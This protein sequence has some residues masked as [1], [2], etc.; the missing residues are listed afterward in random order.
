MLEASGGL[1]LF[2]LG[3]IIL[4][5]GLRGLAGNAI[6]AAL[7]RYTQSP[8]SGA[9][10]GAITTALLQSSSATTVAAV[11]F[12]GAGLMSFPNALGIIFGANIGTTMT[13]WI[14]AVVGFKLNLGLLAYP[15]IMLGVILRLLGRGRLAATGLAIAGFGLIFAGIELLQTAMGGLQQFISPDTLPG[16]SFSGRLVLV[17]LGMVFTII[18]Q[19][20][21][22]GVATALTALHTGAIQFE[23]AAAL[24]IGMDVGTTVTAA[25]ATIGSSVNGKRTGF[26]HVIY[27]IMT[28]AGAFLL[29]TPY[30]WIWQQLA[31]G[32]L[33]HHAEIALVGFHSGFNALGVLAVLPFTYPFARL[34]QQLIQSP[35]KTFSRLFDP[36]LLAQPSEAL[37]EVHK[38]AHEHSLTLLTQLDYLLND[39]PTHRRRIDMI[40]LQLA[41]DETHHFIDRIHLEKL[42][43]PDNERM[44]NLLHLLDHLQ[45][46]HERCDEDTQRAATARES[47]YLRDNILAFKEILETVKTHLENERWIEASN[48]ME[49]T[50]AETK[51]ALEESRKRI[52]NEMAIDTIDVPPGTAELEAIR[53]LKRVNHHL[54]RITL[55]FRQE[56]LASGKEKKAT[57]LQQ[58]VPQNDIS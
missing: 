54:R 1:G 46:L 49:E 18:T 13:G 30:L 8:T 28:G 10:T 56:V 34:M 42:G 35:E 20:S 16:N 51:A 25:V 15:I 58:I 48:L 29:I 38:A 6:R 5:E 44:L 2:L 14:V 21:S 55:H 41:L 47:E 43:S 17:L 12:V 36:A 53:W 3:M 31:P 22:A 50:R 4:T 37:T 33:S 39:S 23:Q 7:M 24:V 32:G 40:E 19:S 27:N 45:R 11:G 26:S 57:V 9:I 52:L